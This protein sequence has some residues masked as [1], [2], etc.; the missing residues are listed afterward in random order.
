MCGGR[1]KE[2]AHDHTPLFTLV[3]L[4]MSGRE[5]SVSR[6]QSPSVATRI[7]NLGSWC[8][9]IETASGSAA[10]ASEMLGSNGHTSTLLDD[11]QANADGNEWKCG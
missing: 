5:S 4:I 7:K 8:A 3:R 9:K 11:V 1:D 10:F 6:Q 2:E